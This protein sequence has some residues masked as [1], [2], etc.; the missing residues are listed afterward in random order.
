MSDLSPHSAL[1]R[2]KLPKPFSVG[3]S[4]LDPGDWIVPDMHLADQLREKAEHFEKRREAVLQAE[5]ATLDAQAETLALLLEYLPRTY[6]DIYKVSGDCV[7]VDPAGLAYRIS[8]YAHAP[9]ELACRLVQD[10]LV[11][12]RKGEDGY[13]IAAAA[14]CFPSTWVLADKFSKPIAEVHAPVPGFGP[15]TRTASLIDRIFDNL[16][17][18]HPAQRCNW[19]IY[20]VADLHHPFSHSTHTRWTDTSGGFFN[21][22]WLRAERQTLTRLPANGDVLFT[23]QIVVDPVSLLMTHPDRSQIAARLKAHIESLDMEQLA[24]KGISDHRDAVLAELS[25]LAEQG[26]Q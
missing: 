20:E 21:G 4:A 9:L 25:M 3:L 16:K 19:S 10:D 15:G 1:H 12:M 26:Q 24:Y 8:D 7:T 13:R 14:V 18:G 17:V 2:D 5:D 6:P 11:I 22:T 23:I